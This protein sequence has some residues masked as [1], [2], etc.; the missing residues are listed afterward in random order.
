MLLLTGFYLQVMSEV[1]H[2]EFDRYLLARGVRLVL[3]GVC[4]HVVS[5]VRHTDLDRCLSAGGVSNTSY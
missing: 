2:A 4:L 5:E 1:R 3:T